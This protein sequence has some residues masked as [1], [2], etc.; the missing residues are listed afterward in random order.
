MMTPEQTT[1]YTLALTAEPT[2]T[3][4]DFL[5][6]GIRF[7][8]WDGKSIQSIQSK[9]DFG[10]RKLYRQKILK[11]ENKKS[12]VAGRCYRTG[13]EDWSRQDGTPLT[14]QDI[15]MINALSYG[16]YTGT[17]NKPGDMVA[18]LTWV[19]DSSD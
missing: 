10:R 13:S 16:Q 15:D 14:Q 6:M 9:I 4:N 12:R 5:E 17:K 11:C 1:D 2:L 18:H 7:Y 8:S 3:Q 19:C